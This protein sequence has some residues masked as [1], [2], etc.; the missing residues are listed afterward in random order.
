M[1]VLMDLIERG[2]IDARGGASVGGGGSGDDV[3]FSVPKLTTFVREQQQE[4]VE[5]W[6]EEMLTFIANGT[7]SQADVDDAVWMQLR[8]FD[9][10]AVHAGL[11]K[12]MSHPMISSVTRKG[13]LLLE[14][15][16]NIQSQSP[17]GLR[18]R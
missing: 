14:I 16:K 18:G 9:P 1:N 5:A 6:E 4:K 7:F 8:E 17:A 2:T 13:V 11:R 10:A 15:L 12:M 3:N